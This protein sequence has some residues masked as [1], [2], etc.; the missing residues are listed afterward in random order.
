MKQVFYMMVGIPGSGKSTIAGMIKNAKVHSSD[1]LR[2]EMFGSEVEQGRNNE[3]FMELHRRIFSDLHSG[4]SVV[5]DAT[6]ISSRRRKEF[7]REVSN[8][9][10]A[11]RVCIFVRTNINE[12]IIRNKRR[13]RIVPDGVIRRMSRSLDIPC[14]SEG[15]DC[16][17][18]G[19]KFAE[20]NYEMGVE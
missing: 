7:L 15:W 19:E 3:L 18:D 4:N 8:L 20:V 5:Y 9:S 13:N 16:I 10:S 11:I 6:N 14:M 2:A 1:S 12:C 17:I